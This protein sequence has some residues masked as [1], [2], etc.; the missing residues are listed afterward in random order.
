MKK[1]EIGFV[2]TKVDKGIELVF[3]DKIS[4]EDVVL[5][6]IV[7]R[8]KAGALDYIDINCAFFGQVFREKDV[9]EIIKTNVFYEV[10][11]GIAKR[12]YR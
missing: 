5:C 12:I 8:G 11:D 2:I 9:F 4:K 7:F 6:P 10:K 1:K 3:N